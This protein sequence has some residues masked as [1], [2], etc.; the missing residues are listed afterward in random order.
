M[1]IDYEGDVLTERIIKAIIRVHSTLGPGF[2]ESIYR[3]ALVIEFKKQGLEVEV[4]KEITVYYDGEVVGRHRL[5]LLVEG[6]V[7]LELK[8]VADIGK[9]HYA[10]IPRI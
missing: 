2:L 4:E 9:A 1:E 7:V 8:T 6:R 10:Q 3:N 5:D